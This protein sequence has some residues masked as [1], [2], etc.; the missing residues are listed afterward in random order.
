[1]EEALLS[2]VNINGNDKLLINYHIEF[3]E[4]RDEWAESMPEIKDIIFTAD[5]SDLP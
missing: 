1:M 3:N 2:K 4:Y 5:R